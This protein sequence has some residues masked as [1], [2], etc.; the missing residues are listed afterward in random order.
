[1]ARW[2]PSPE[3]GGEPLGPARREGKARK[4]KGMARKTED[5][6]AT[7]LFLPFLPCLL[8]FL[9]RERSPRSKVIQVKLS[10]GSSQSG[11]NEVRANASAA[12]RHAH[13]GRPFN[14]LLTFGEAAN[15]TPT[16]DDR[17]DCGVPLP[18]LR[19]KG[20]VRRPP[21][22]NREVSAYDTRPINALHGLGSFGIF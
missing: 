14:E 1:M 18:E 7:H 10:K 9:L 3:V 13:Q 21:D 20:C 22:P 5:P 12:E 11:G 16:T 6:E 19:L 2:Q 8:S 17:Y 4:E 15:P